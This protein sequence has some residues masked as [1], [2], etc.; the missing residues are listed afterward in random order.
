MSLRNINPKFAE[1]QKSSIS[2]NTTTDQA[3]SMTT[4]SNEQEVSEQQITKDWKQLSQ[5]I[6]TIMTERMSELGMSQRKLGKI[7]D[8]T[9]QYISDILKG[10]RNMTLE[11]ICKIE[12][13]LGIEI[14][15]MNVNN[16]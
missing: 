6:A 14:I 16:K 5:L 15:K 13:A 11:T 12:N 7:M 9:Q 10:Q 8:C 4:T 2:M 1:K 3:L